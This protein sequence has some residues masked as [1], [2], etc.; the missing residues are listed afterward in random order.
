MSAVTVVLEWRFSP[1]D[2]FEEPITISR[3]DYVMVID[4]GH[5][6]ATIASAVYDADPSMLTSLHEA[7]N[8]RMYGVQLLSHKPFELSKPTI[9]RL[10][11][12]GRRDISF[13]LDCVQLKLSCGDADVQVIDKDGNVVSDSKR[14]RIEKKKSLAELVRTYRVGDVLLTS[15]LKSYYAGVRDPANELVHLYEIRE[16]LSAHFSSNALART[17]LGLSSS[18]WSRLGQLCCDGQLRQG[19]HRG[20]SIGTLRDATEAE[21]AEARD[22][23]RGMIKA[24]LRHKM[25]PTKGAMT[26]TIGGTD[27]P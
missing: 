22:I 9:I 16:S 25:R 21:L 14:D 19:R 24:Y 23:V 10:H 11:P 27:G 3:K 18:E 17:T 20:K 6:N 12:D 1:P 4:S 13:E 8:D 26:A 5:V 7:M 15:L 2:F